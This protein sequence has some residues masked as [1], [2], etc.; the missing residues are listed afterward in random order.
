MK[1]AF[2]TVDVLLVT[3]VLTV[4]M[5]ESFVK[6]VQMLT[7]LVLQKILPLDNLDSFCTLNLIRQPGLMIPTLR[8]QE[9]KVV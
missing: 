8:L 9:L 6:V 2:G 4:R 5:L 7:H 1:T 3:I